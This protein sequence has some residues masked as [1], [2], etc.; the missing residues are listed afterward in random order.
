MNPGRGTERILLVEDD[1]SVRRFVKSTLEG[2]GYRVFS[3]G[4]GTEALDKL[5][6]TATPPDLLLTD[7]VIPGMDGRALAH[8]TPGG[9]PGCVSSSYRDTPRIGGAP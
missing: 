4:S 6:E 2:A 1:D 7:V 8:D 5:E 9:S 3:A